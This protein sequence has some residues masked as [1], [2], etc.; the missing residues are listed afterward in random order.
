MKLIYS[1]LKN[2]FLPQLD[3]EP[4]QLASD[5]AMIG[6]FV[7]GLTT[8]DNKIVLNLEIRQ[9]RGDCLGYYGLARDLSVWY[10]TPLVLPQITPQAH[11]DYQ[12]PITIS[13][14]DVKRIQALKISHVKNSLSPDWLKQF[15]SLHEI[16]SVN[17]VVDLTN[18]I[19]F[20]WGIPN[21][22]FD[23]AISTDNLI[24]ENNHRYSTFTTLDGTTLNLPPQ[25]LIVSNPTKPLSLSFLGGQDCAIQLDTSDI[26]IEA[27]VYNRSRVKND[28][29]TLKTTTETEIRLDKELDTEL[30][31][32]ALNHLAS[33]ICQLTSGQVS[34]Q[35]FDY[36]PQRYT[37]TPIEFDPKLASV[38]SGINIPPDFA[39]DCLARLGCTI[40]NNLVT[41]PSIRKDISIP[42][43]LSEEVIRFYG[44]QK[45]PNN[46][47][48][49][50]KN[51][52]DITPKIIYLIEQLKDKLVALGYDE[53]RSWPLVRQA[54]DPSTV[55]TT[56][57]SI[58]SE[59]PHLRQ[60]MIQSLETQLDQY[61]RLKLP[62]PQ[63][64]EISK[65]FS[66]VNGQYIEKFA[67]GLYHHNQDE[68]Q[69]D[70]QKLNL[71]ATTKD[72]FAEIILDDLDKPD[73]YTPQNINSTA[74]ELTSQIITLDANVSFDSPQDPAKL[75]DK[76]TAAIDPLILW[77]LDIV[78]VFQ[79]KYT[80]RV[81]YYNCD[82]KTA[83]KVHLSAFNLK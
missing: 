69:I 27:A 42:E 16:N 78:D 53:I 43:D 63:F 48:P 35:L 32:L 41:P 46:Q 20:L 30:V 52:P 15:L 58:N 14:P 26:L 65:I 66:L 50:V 72:N 68:L 57:N 4:Q 67:L 28:S 44:Y 17:T 80:F 18:Y 25:T 2:Q 1:I 56:Q 19:M 82:D 83:K 36:Y 54:L 37:T 51:L 76:Y 10:N 59:Y 22:A 49:A 23:T 47:P 21:H 77:S 55:V 74:I 29:R 71:I 64:F 11:T 60:S 38:Q 62:S 13:S 24:W 45:I 70:L 31:P 34:S 81:S 8:I 3:V 61:Q 33:L 5:L 75:I 12:L 6:H 39:L 9:N 79:N 73:S 40:S 7:S